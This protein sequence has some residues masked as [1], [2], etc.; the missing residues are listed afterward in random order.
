MSNKT[1]TV[2]ELTEDETT[3]LWETLDII[4]CNAG[5]LGND[6]LNSESEPIP[7][8]IH[9]ALFD[10]LPDWYVKEFVK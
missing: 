1:T 6:S 4:L 5:H 9:R 10:V 7:R 3:F 2:L 8:A